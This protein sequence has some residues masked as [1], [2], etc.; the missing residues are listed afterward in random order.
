MTTTK[1]KRR[2]TTKRRASS[3]DPL[4]VQISVRAKLPKGRKPSPQLIQ[5]A[6]RY[7]VEHG[8]DHPAFKTRIIRWR[9]GGRRGNLSAWRQGNQSDAWGTLGKWLAFASVGVTTVRSR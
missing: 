3:R 2:R 4:Q 7:R 8:E 6:I 9:N 5:D 1:S